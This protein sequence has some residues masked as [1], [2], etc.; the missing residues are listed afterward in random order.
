MIAFYDLDVHSLPECADSASR[1]WLWA[2][3]FG[4][5][6]IAVT[7]HSDFFEQLPKQEGIFQGV[8]I[9]AS[10]EGELDSK[11]ATYRPRVD[12]LAVHGSSE[13]VNRAAL[14]DLRVDILAH[15]EQAGNSGI[16]HVLAKLAG[17]NQVAIEFNLNALI[18]SRGGI[19]SRVLSR[20]NRNYELAR[21]FGAPVV[22]TSGA[23]SHYDLRAPMDMAA[24]AMLFGM[25][26]QEAI[27]SLS[28]EPLRI[29]KRKSVKRIFRG[30]E[31]VE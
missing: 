22:L 3:Q 6:G 24:L 30:V 25:S 18:H 8:E 28:A 13:K 4:Y 9:T 10:T 31:V 5:S 7:N 12:V 2:K 23:R 17:Q 19:R 20:F 27:Y 16:N 15:P 11:I 26:R 14:E 29:L 1:L 21:K